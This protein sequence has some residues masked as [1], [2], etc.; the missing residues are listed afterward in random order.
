MNF[1]DLGLSDELLR[2]VADTGYL[3]P[4][5]IQADAIPLILMGRDILG[6]AQTGTGKTASFT[7]PMIDILSSGRAR[8]RMPRTLI[9]APTRE[10]ATQ[11]GDC[12]DTY[13]K[14]S[15][16]TKAL[17]IGGE[18]FDEQYKTLDKGVDVLIATPGRILDVLARGKVLLNDVKILVIDEADRMLDMGFI[19]DVEKIVSY[20]GKIRQTL[21]FSATMP[22][23]IRALADNFLLN[24]KE[25]SINPPSTAGK[26]IDHSLIKIHHKDKKDS[27]S[28]NWK[29]RKKLRQ[30]LSKEDISNVLIFCNRKR[31]VE[32][33]NKSLLKHGFNSSCLHG[34]MPQNQR[35]ETMQTFKSENINILVC[36]DVAARGLDIDDISHV[37]NFDVPLHPEDY[38]HRIG[39]TGRAGKSGKA[40]TLYWGEDD[41]LLSKIS[42]TIGKQIPLSELYNRDE[43]DKDSDVGLEPRKK[44]TQPQKKKT[45]KSNKNQNRI[46]KEETPTGLGDHIPA[47]LIK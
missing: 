7:L 5:P 46:V 2:A 14:Y 26:N 22:E 40:F 32:I 16:L 31:V 11:V 3:E 37:I 29:K 41:Q 20:L 44:P 19:P 38:V 4:T 30:I 17:I 8:A 39:R 13:G 25:I 27:E 35:T 10:L 33:V 34:D 47:F 1:S 45:T 6:C 15:K 24:P 21:M 9:I 36:S 43:A 18:S 12:F 42:S 28:L 23:E